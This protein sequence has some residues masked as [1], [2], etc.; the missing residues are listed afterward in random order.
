MNTHLSKPTC[1]GSLKE[2][3][4]DYARFYHVDKIYNMHKHI[5]KNLNKDLI[6]F[7]LEF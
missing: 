3:W 2:F 6:D 5:Y 1:I 4:A 7:L